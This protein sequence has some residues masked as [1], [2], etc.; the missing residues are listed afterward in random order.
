MRRNIGRLTD[1]QLFINHG[2]QRIREEVVTTENGYRHDPRRPYR[3]GFPAEFRNLRAAQLDLRSRATCRTLWSGRW[4]RT[5]ARASA[6]TRKSHVA[7][8]DRGTDCRSPD[9]G[10]RPLQVQVETGAPRCYCGNSV[11][12][13]DLRDMDISRASASPNTSPRW[14]PTSSNT[15]SRCAAGTRAT[16]SSPTACPAARR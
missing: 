1:A 12:Y 4:S 9:P 3:P 11:L 10:G 13:F 15:R 14:M 2:I 6:S 5:P 16:G 8:V 7:Y